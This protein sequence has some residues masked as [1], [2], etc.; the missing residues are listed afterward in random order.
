MLECHRCKRD[1]PPED[2]K[3]TLKDIRREL[4]EPFGPILAPNFL[5]RNVVEQDLYQ[6]LKQAELL[7]IL[8]K[9]LLED[10]EDSEE[11]ANEESLHSL[12]TQLAF[13]V[14]MVSLFHLQDVEDD[15]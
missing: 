15:F 1:A 7:Q 9:L 11:A 8:E 12:Q 5:I 6:R 4:L 14:R 10:I 2:A 3:A 13:L